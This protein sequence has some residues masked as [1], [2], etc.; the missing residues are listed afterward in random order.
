MSVVEKQIKETL[1]EKQPT[2]DVFK[3]MIIFW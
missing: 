2:F 1:K 3:V